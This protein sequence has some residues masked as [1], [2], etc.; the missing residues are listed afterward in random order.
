[1]TAS[2]HHSF[3]RTAATE[4]T[5]VRLAFE[6]GYATLSGW[7]PTRLDVEGTVQSEDA[8]KLRALFGERLRMTERSSTS[9]GTRAIAATVESVDR[10]GEYRRAIRA[11]MA[12]LVAAIARDERLEV[13]AADGLRSL[14]VALLA[15]QDQ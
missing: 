3:N 5:E 1:M 9:R 6:R 4:R 2:L 14:D 15:S 13:T 11:G 7:I 8:D 10:Q 12:N